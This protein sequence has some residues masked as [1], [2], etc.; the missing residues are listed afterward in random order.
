MQSEED[1]GPLGFD[2]LI[3]DNKHLGIAFSPIP[4][5]PQQNKDLAILFWN[6]P[7]IAGKVGA[8]FSNVLIS[9]GGPT[10]KYED[11]EAQWRGLTAKRASGSGGA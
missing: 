8:W 5:K 9:P 4:G 7:E 10:I 2:L 1:V 11:A 6:Q 3:V